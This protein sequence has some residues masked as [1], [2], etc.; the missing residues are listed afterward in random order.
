MVLAHTHPQAIYR[1]STPRHDYN[2]SL[3]PMIYAPNKCYS[4][5]NFVCLLLEC[6]TWLANVTKTS[7][8]MIISIFLFLTLN[9]I[10][11]FIHHFRSSI[12]RGDARARQWKTINLFCVFFLFISLHNCRR[13]RKSCRVRFSIRWMII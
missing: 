9:F 4:R 11:F 5:I 8:N 2:N 12:F 13:C 3:I 1:S 7:I 6:Y 10:I